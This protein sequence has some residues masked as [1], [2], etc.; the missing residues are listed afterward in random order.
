MPGGSA[1]T[2]AAGTTPILIWWDYLQDGDRSRRSRLE[3]DDPDATRATPRYYSQAITQDAPDPA[4]ARLWEE[5]LYSTDGQNLLLAGLRPS[6]ELPAMVA[7]QHGQQACV[8]KLPAAPRGTVTLPDAGPA[9]DGRERRSTPTGPR[10]SAVAS[11]LI[12]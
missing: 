5:F 8:A 7:D 2:A 1:A 12:G 9:L 3:V 11:Q 4:A 6:D 10:R